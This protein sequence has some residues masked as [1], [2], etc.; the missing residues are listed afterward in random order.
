MKFQFNILVLVIASAWSFS[1]NDCDKCLWHRLEVKC[2]DIEFKVL[3]N[4]CAL[5][6]APAPLVR[7]TLSAPESWKIKGKLVWCRIPPFI[8]KM[9]DVKMNW[10][11]FT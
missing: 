8:L 9:A 11:A 10:A 7:V 1:Y 5:S 4:D 2:S 6:P 3:H